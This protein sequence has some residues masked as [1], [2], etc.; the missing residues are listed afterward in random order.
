MASSPEVAATTGGYLMSLKSSPSRQRRSLRFVARTTESRLCLSLDF[1]AGDAHGPRVA[2]DPRRGDARMAAPSGDVRRVQLEGGA[3]G[4]ADVRRRRATGRAVP[5]RRPPA[6]GP[7]RGQGPALLRLRRRPREA[8]RLLAA[9]RRRL[10]GR[11][12]GTRR[13]GSSAQ[14]H[15]LIDH[16]IIKRRK[17]FCGLQ[18][19]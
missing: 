4:G 6:G 3:G 18:T 1:G 16:R 15:S 9:P 2:A 7:G 13:T 12:P 14:R 5:R 8:R 10:H 17:F 19:T 11:P